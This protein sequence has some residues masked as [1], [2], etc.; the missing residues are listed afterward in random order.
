MPKIKDLRIKATPQ[1]VMLA[2]VRGGDVKP[3]PKG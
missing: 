2:I 3:K 1:Q